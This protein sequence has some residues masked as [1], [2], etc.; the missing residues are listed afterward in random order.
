[1]RGKLACAVTALG[2][3]AMAPGGA[4]ADTGTHKH[5]GR[6]HHQTHHR[7]RHKDQ[8]VQVLAIND[9]HGNI[10]PP[11]GSSG[12]VPVG[13]NPDGTTATE[14]AGGVEYLKTWVDRLRREPGHDRS[15]FV[16]AGDLIGA[17]PLVSGLFHDEPT[18]QA[19]NKIGM[20]FSSVGNHEFDEGIDELHRMQDGGC[21]PTDTAGSCQGGIP[22]RGAAFRYLAANVFTHGTNQTIF[23][24]Y[25]VVRAGN[26][27]LAFIGMTLEGT[28]DI[29]TP[30]GV[31]GLDFRDEAQTANA[32]VRRLRR[33][34]GVR[35]FVV[36]IHQGDQQNPPYAKGYQ[37]VNGCENLTGDLTP[38]LGQLSRRI[39]VVVSAHTHQAYNC[40]IGGRLVT[41]AASF[42]RLVTDLNLTI[43]HRTRRI[44]RS[45]ATNVIVSRDVAK[46]PGETRLV[47]RYETASGPIAH[48]VVGTITS[49]FTRTQNAA[50]ESTLG[51]LIADSQLEAAAPSDFGSAVVAFMNP[52][53]IRADLPYANSDGGEAPG[54]VTYNELYT[55]QPF[56]NTMVVKTMTGDMIRR[57]L[58]QQFDNP[59]AGQNR[60]LQVSRG[61]HYTWDGS[62]PAGQ[63]VSAISI[64][65]TPVTPTGSYRVAMNNFLATGGDG[66]T[67]FNEGTDQLGGA[68]DID[69]FGAYIGA[70]SPAAPQPLDRI[71]KAG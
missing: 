14:A 15:Y 35:A 53:G 47:Q 1:M 19:L 17:S 57:L 59:S 51:D 71:T 7:H 52:G 31:A 9:L 41:S 3:F 16:G 42:G 65:G 23:P 70:H 27:K 43:S 45:R 20:D 29:V 2:L 61:F 39:S 6:G 33:T 40:R 44:T 25:K 30:S 54:Q 67:V 62:K 66:F 28:P 22:F 64:G 48:R 37:D 11:V 10:Q 26:A 8:H 55:V 24:P 46:D 34:Q 5:H 36:L 21:H 63:R 56:S 38:I 12:A 18:I 60:F 58:E 4:L 68:V 69:A 50:G 32:L 49:D 13:V